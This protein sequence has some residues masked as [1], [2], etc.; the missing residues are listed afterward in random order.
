[1]DD[2]AKA[3]GSDVI[4]KEE[5]L[6]QAT[7]GTWAGIISMGLAMVGPFTCYTSYFLSFPLGLFS[8]W[9]SWRAY[10]TVGG[11][12]SARAERSL[13]AAGLASGAISAL[14]SGMFAMLFLMIVALYFVLF[15]IGILGGLA[16]EM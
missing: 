3:I 13:A 16:S 5:A 15:V 12:P 14:F 8:V 10:G 4:L 6:S 2:I 9:S 11:L 7:T 1:M